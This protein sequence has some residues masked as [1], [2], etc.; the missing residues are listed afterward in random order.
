MKSKKAME[1]RTLIELIL[2]VI[3]TLTI[4]LPLGSKILDYWRG[5]PAD[6]TTRSLELL[7]AEINLLEENE[8]RTVPVYIDAH[9]I[10]KG[11]KIDSKN[12]PPDCQPTLKGEPRKAC[13]C[14][15]KKDTCDFIKQEVNECKKIDFNLVEEKSYPPKISQDSGD[16]II[17][18]CKLTK[19][20]QTITISCV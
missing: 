16:A 1:T 20:D 4:G 15:C 13:L 14:I 6:G 12:K 10:I 18:N 5:Q 19:Q 7:K 17:Q 11:Y 9:H 2:F 8:T 3:I